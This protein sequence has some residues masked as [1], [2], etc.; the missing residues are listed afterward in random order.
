[1]NAPTAG[2]GAVFLDKDG[3]LLDDIPFNVD[4]DR[5]RLA[6]GAREG[7]EALG[8]AGLPL[9]VVSNQSGIA[10][11][12]FDD[13]AMRVVERKLE[14][15]FEECG[16]RMSGF[17]YCPHHPAATVPAYALL[18]SCR[19]PEPGMLFRA[20]AEHGVDPMRSWMVGDILDDIEAG[21]RAGCA[22]ILLDNGNE[23]EWDL[24]PRRVPDHRVPTLDQAARLIVGT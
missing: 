10:R 20:S 1:M 13:S 7:L 23:T 21:R 11:G 3:T 5:M 16:A 6:E 18:C 24:S 14:T 15:L 12:L 17:F 8:G 2:R 22:T 9:F 19:K 4:P